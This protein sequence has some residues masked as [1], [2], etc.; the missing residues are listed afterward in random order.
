MQLVRSHVRRPRIGIYD[1]YTPGLG[2]LYRYVQGVLSGLEPHEFDVTLFCH[3]NCPFVVPPGTKVIPVLPHT[4]SPIIN[5]NTVLTS[6][7]VTASTTTASQSLLSRSWRNLTPQ[8][9]RVVLGFIRSAVKT[10][11]LLRPYEFDLVHSFETDADPAI[12]AARLAN[13]RTVL[14]T[15][16]VDSSYRTPEIQRCPGHRLTEMIADHAMTHG[17][18]A[19]SQTRS[20]RLKRTHVGPKKIRTILNGIDPDRFVRTLSKSQAR[21]MTGLPND[22][23]IILG[24]TGRLHRHKGQEFLLRAVH[25]L[26]RPNVLLVIAGSGELQDYLHKLALELKIENQ[27]LLLGQRSDISELL[28]AFD[29]FA[30]PSICEALPYS[31]LEA[32]S[33]GVP[34]IATTVGGVAELIENGVSGYLVPPSNVIELANSLQKL[35]NHSESELDLMSK[36]ARNRVLCSFH[37]RVNINELIKIY[38]A[39]VPNTK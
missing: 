33:M 31:L 27:V 39:A 38:K 26:R 25:Q 19:S 7:L 13:V 4:S 32:M 34:S 17:I 20:D 21:E 23:R 10:A 3:P 15:Y 6:E 37:E 11:T 1:P 8:S 14:Y 28:Q 36:A 5:T 24:T 2:G 29:L 18:A 16:Q 12:L 35:L 30:L 22:G 9:L